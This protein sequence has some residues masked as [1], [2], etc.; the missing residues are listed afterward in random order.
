MLVSRRL[1]QMACRDVEDLYKL[2]QSCR[3]SCVGLVCHA[4]D[5]MSKVGSDK[6]KALFRDERELYLSVV[7]VL[8]FSPTVCVDLG[9]CAKISVA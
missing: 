6:C 3:A 7:R 4:S 2:C 8:H 9:N 5:S 1:A